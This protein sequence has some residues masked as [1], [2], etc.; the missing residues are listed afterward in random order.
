MEDRCVMC[1]EYVPEGSMVCPVCQRKYSGRPA[2]SRVDRKAICPDCGTIQAL[3][4]A[5]DALGHG[6]T[7][8]QWEEFYAAVKG[9]VTWI[10]R[11]IMPV[12]VRTRLLMMQFAPR[13]KRRCSDRIG[14]QEMRTR[15]C[16]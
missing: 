14:R 16:L 11:F 13:I 5:R 7:D 3:D 1:G 9:G 10:K 15:I 4:D 8:Q 2:M 12:D 6:M